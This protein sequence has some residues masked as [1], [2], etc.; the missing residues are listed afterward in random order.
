MNNCKPQNQNGSQKPNFYSLY[1]LVGEIKGT[2]Q[3]I[4]KKVETINGTLR[5]HDNRID[6]LKERADKMEGRSA[7]IA[8]ITSFLVAVAGALIT[9]FKLNK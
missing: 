8:A 3:A 6:A 4:D 1:E 7:G 9:I 5:L 2:V